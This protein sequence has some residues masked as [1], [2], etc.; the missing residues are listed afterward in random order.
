MINRWLSQL[1][2][3]RRRPIA[4]DIGG[5]AV[6][7]LNLKENTGTPIVDASQ[8]TPLKPGIVVDGIVQSPE[9]LGEAIA[10]TWDRLEVN[11]RRVGLALPPNLTFVM[12]IN[13]D[14]NRVG[15]DLEIAI[16]AEANRSVPYPL[17]D[18]YY[19]YE[20]LGVEGRRKR[21]RIVCAHKE[22][23]D[24]RVAAVEH[25]GLEAAFMDAA[26]YCVERTLQAVFATITLANK[27]DPQ[28]YLDIGE[29]GTRF[30]VFYQEQMV[31]LKSLSLGL[32]VLF[33]RLNLQY[34]LSW[35]EYI[36]LM[37]RREHNPSFHEGMANFANLLAQDIQREIELFRATTS[38]AMP[39]KLWLGGG[40][41]SI[42]EI[43]QSLAELLNLPT[44]SI[45]LN[46]LFPPAHPGLSAQYLWVV[47]LG[48][49]IR[50]E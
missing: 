33:E 14:A 50:K 26:Q 30:Y 41:A 46:P 7:M 15:E 36:V 18:I 12:E 20:I 44:E 47:A 8:I 11:Q 49:A 42:L 2:G 5:G 45:S 25:A 31:Y 28:V 34:G 16:E 24:E 37:M 19:G 10:S 40:G 39:T 23:V 22:R 1:F 3:K 38:F 4:L 27:S 21:V 13:V 32:G 43:Q 9:D 35:E 29:S 48:I 6:K 17:D